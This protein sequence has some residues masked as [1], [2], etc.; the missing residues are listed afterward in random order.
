MKHLFI[1]CVIFSLINFNCQKENESR[2][3]DVEGITPVR[4]QA[5]EGSIIIFHFDDE[6]ILAK[7]FNINNHLCPDDK[8]N[9]C[10]D[11]GYLILKLR[12]SRGIEFDSITLRH[13]VGWGWQTAIDSATIIFNPDTFRTYLSRCTY[14]NEEINV[15]LQMKKF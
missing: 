6:I 8:N 2:V 1:I 13:G 14:K 11:V 15:T 10:D 5:F 12:I 7:I 3:I 9:W 4:F